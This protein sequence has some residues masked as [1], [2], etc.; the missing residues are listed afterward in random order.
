MVCVLVRVFL[1][2]FFILCP[3]HFATA[4][5]LQFGIY[6]C[7]VT[8]D[9]L[10]GQEIWFHMLNTPTHLH[11]VYVLA[12]ETV[13]SALVGVS[14]D[15]FRSQITPSQIKFVAGIKPDSDNDVI[16][17][18]MASKDSRCTHWFPSNDAME[19]EAPKS[20]GG[21]ENEA[22]RGPKK[23][24]STKRTQDVSDKSIF[25]QLKSMKKIAIVAACDDYSNC[26]KWENLSCATNDGNLMVSVLEKLGWN[27]T[28]KL[29][30]QDCTKQKIVNAFEEITE[31][32]GGFDQRQ[33]EMAQVLVFFA[34]HGNA[35]NR[36]NGKNEGELIMSDY[37]PASAKTRFHMKRLR[38]LAEDLPVQQGRHDILSVSRYSHRVSSNSI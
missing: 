33:A 9:A 18:E 16:G 23:S 37:D 28:H 19:N 20:R 14:R 10:H 27:V 22:A 36:F 13:T 15:F 17:E 35:V 34:G 4:A 12:Y 5:L 32:F 8:F 3:L 29:Y 26:N 31:M 7:L 25:E 6:Q 1:N 38:G 2:S 21:G 11:S 24:G 30:N